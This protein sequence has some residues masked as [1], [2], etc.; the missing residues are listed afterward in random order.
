MTANFAMLIWP[1]VTSKSRP[2]RPVTPPE[3]EKSIP[4]NGI[5]SVSCTNVSLV[6]LAYS[7]NKVRCRDTERVPIKQGVDG[8]R[9]PGL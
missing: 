3:A 5:L 8:C 7:Y 6:G 2:F 4:L 1:N 9:A